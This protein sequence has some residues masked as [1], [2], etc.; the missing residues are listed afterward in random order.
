MEKTNI[1]Y[2]CLAKVVRDGGFKIA[3]VAR[4]SAI[5]GHCES[6][7][8]VSPWRC[9]FNGRVT[10]TT[11]VFSTCGMNVFVF[12]IAAILSLPKQFITVYLGVI[13][14]QSDTGKL[15]SIFDPHCDSRLSR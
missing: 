4:L 10:V 12:S 6:R 14:E 9:D 7:S 8:V 13:L 15:I 2:A 3:L 5:P 1:S 11:A